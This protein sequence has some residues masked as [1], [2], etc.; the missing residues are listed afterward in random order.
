MSDQEQI[1]A[2]FARVRQSQSE[3]DF[4]IC[5]RIAKLADSQFETSLS[6]AAEAVSN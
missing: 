4:S 6:E 1:D 5:D 3:R 2:W